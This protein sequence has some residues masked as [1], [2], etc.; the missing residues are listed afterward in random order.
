VRNKR[1]FPDLSP[2]ERRAGVRQR[3]RITLGIA[4]V[5]LL[6]AALLLVVDVLYL[7]ALLLVGFG[8]A[9]IFTGLIALVTH[10]PRA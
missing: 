6:V 7:P 3:A 5:M 2:E 10:D 4:T 8:S 1:P 9:G